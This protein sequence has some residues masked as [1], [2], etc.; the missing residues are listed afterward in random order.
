MKDTKALARLCKEELEELTGHNAQAKRQDGDDAGAGRH[1]A[2]L[3]GHNAQAKRQVLLST[4]RWWVKNRRVGKKKIIEDTEN[5]AYLADLEERAA[6]QLGA[7][8]FFR[9]PPN[10]DY[11]RDQ[12][13]WTVALYRVAER[14]ILPKVKKE[15]KDNHSPYL[16]PHS[17]FGE[18]LIRECIYVILREYTEKKFTYQGLGQ[19]VEYFA[20]AWRLRLRQE[21][22]PVATEAVTETELAERMQRLAVEQA[23]HDVS[24]PLLR[25][26]RWKIWLRALGR[27][28]AIRLWI[29]SQLQEDRNR[30]WAEIVELIPE[31]HCGVLDDEDLPPGTTW[32]EVDQAFRK[33]TLNPKAVRRRAST[34]GKI[35]RQA[36]WELMIKDLD[37]ENAIRFW[38][39]YI[40]RE[41]RLQEWR[42]IVERMQKQYCEILAA[43]DKDRDALPPEILWQEVHHVLQAKK[44]SAEELR[45]WYLN[46]KQH[47]W[48]LRY[49]LP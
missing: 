32:D 6:D 40:L 25:V 29:L 9:T 41:T 43:K 36:L 28:R 35:V 34:D 49:G 5:F 48:E 39:V 30:E 26:E 13:W 45:K 44:Y 18:D 33:M 23:S 14:V 24:E 12:V 19:A 7:D 38:I 17:I 11:L 27:R 2:E 1:G 22:I 46:I 42:E 31:P 20:E 21:P 8:L 3:T 10:R 4:V 47:C 15:E 37:R 16:P